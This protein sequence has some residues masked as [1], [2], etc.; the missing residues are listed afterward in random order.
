MTVISLAKKVFQDLLNLKNYIGSAYGI[1]VIISK[2]IVRYDNDAFAC[3][4]VHHDSLQKSDVRL[5][6]IASQANS[7]CRYH[8]HLA[9]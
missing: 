7:L 4:R 5:M 2:P 6:A 9:N 3:L 8:S 1:S